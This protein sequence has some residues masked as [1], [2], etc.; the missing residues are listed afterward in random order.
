[1]DT[2]CRKGERYIFHR[3]N[4]KV[5]HA[6]FVEMIENTLFVR[7]YSDDDGECNGKIRSIPKEWI[8]SVEQEEIQLDDICCNIN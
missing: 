6:T 3:T 8:A 1:M 2:I 4:G 5:F 7:E